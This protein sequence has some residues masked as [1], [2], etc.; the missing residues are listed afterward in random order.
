L[1][2]GVNPMSIARILF[3]S[4]FSA[5]SSIWLI[6]ERACRARTGPVHAAVTI[7]EDRRFRQTLAVP[8]PLATTPPPHTPRG[9]VTLQ[10]I[11]HW[12]WERCIE[13]SIND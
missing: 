2:R 7:D 6:P 8:A 9:H 5:T 4:P 11:I 13:D 1:I 3:P 10:Y 12:T